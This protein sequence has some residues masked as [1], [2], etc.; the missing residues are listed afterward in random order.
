MLRL[1]VA[2]DASD[3]RAMVRCFCR[4]E[5]PAL[6]A[7]E[8]KLSGVIPQCLEA[9]GVILSCSSDGEPVGTVGLVV[10]APFWSGRRWMIALWSYVRPDHRHEPHM[11][12]MLRAA[13]AAA[14]EQHMPLRIEVWGGPRTGGK[15]HLFER[16]LGHPA[17]AL[18]L[19]RG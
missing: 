3:V 11:R 18:F 10:D 13:K 16:E 8:A 9:G 5:M 6:P 15:V 1:G 12:A 14:Q 2:D 7:D 19:V 4:E 17:G